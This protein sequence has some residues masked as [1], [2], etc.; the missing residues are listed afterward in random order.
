MNARVGTA[1]TRRRGRRWLG[2]VCLAVASLVIA[3]TALEVG[4]RLVAPQDLRF[5]DWTTV[6]RPSAKAGQSYEYIPGAHNPRYIG[7]PVSINRLG[8]RDG[9]VAIPKPAGTLR[10]VA[11]GDS[12]TFGYGVRL[13]DTWVKTLERRLN[14]TGGHRHE[15]VNAGVEAT[16]IEYY[17]SF[18]RT[19]AAALEPDLLVVG[20]ALNDVRWYRGDRRPAEEGFKASVFRLARTVNT[21]LV[22][23]SHVYL[24]SYLSLKSILYGSGI[25]DVSRA[26]AYDFEALVDPSPSQERAWES[27]E[28]HLRATIDAARGRGWP[29]AFVVFP[30]EPQLGPAAAELYRRRLGMVISQGAEAGEP[31]R[32]LA[33]FFAGQDVPML[34]L[35]PAYRGGEDLFLRN[36]AISHDPAHPSPVGHGIAGDA[37]YRFIADQPALRTGI[38]R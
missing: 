2:Q 6:K 7:V 22:L 1:S 14:A 30:V 24:A 8:L 17:E 33:R 36:A 16:G 12:V 9:D 32:R 5:F 13:E 3:V 28:R 26:H 29:I 21:K 10:V 4:V 38:V 37:I 18:I 23:N 25:I 15:V 19:Q 27:T 20:I 11:V 34:D 31:Q 35:L